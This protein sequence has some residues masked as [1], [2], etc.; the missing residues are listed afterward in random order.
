LRPATIRQLQDLFSGD[1]AGAAEA[2]ALF[3]QVTRED[4]DRLA[5]AAE[6]GDA[7]DVFERA[8]RITGSAASFGA[9]VLSDR[10]RAV[11]RAARAGEVPAPADV[12][13]LIDLQRRSAAALRTALALDS[14]G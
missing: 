11:C 14:A 2:F 13:D 1:S 5:T 8:H 10:C 3:E 6:E 9:G 7:G 4:L 12:R